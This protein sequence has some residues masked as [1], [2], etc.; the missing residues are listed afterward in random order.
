MLPFPAALVPLAAMPRWVLWRWQMKPERRSGKPRDPADRGSWTKP[1][2]TTEGRLARTDEDGD[3]RP[4][5]DLFPALSTGSFSGAGFAPRAEDGLLFLDL[6]ECRDKE[7]GAVAAWAAR[8]AA[9]CRSYCEVSPSGTGLRIVGLAGGYAGSPTKT[10]FVLTAEGAEAD[11]GAEGKGEIYRG[12]NYVTITFNA[13]PEA[14][15]ALADISA[16]AQDILLR[17]ALRRNA[18]VRGEISGPSRDPRAP[19][20]VVHETLSVIPNRQVSWHWWKETIGMAV[21]AATEGSEEGLAAWDEWSR[22]CEAY[23][24]GC[25]CDTE[26]ERMCVSPPDRTGFGTLW[27]EAAASETAAGRRWAGGPQWK[28][29]KTQLGGLSGLPGFEAAGSTDGAAE[30]NSE[31]ASPAGLAQGQERVRPTIQVVAGK[32]SETADA[33]EQALVLGGWPVYTRDRLLVM[34]SVKEV[35][36]RGGGKATVAGL[37]KMGPAAL[38]DVLAK[39]AVWVKWDGRSQRLVACDPPSAVV[40]V[41]LERPGPRPFPEVSGISATPGLRADG[42]IS[43]GTGY[44]P[45]L[46][47]HRVRDPHLHMPGG[48]NDRPPVRAD[49]EVALG[50]LNGLLEG[51][52]FVDD[53]DRAVALAMILTCVCRCA[54]PVAPVFAV[55][56]TMPGTGKSHLVDLASAIATGQRC[57]AAGAGR[58]DEETEKRL[59][60]LI[61][62]GYPLVSI[63][64]L[65]GT[66][67]SDTLSQ[68]VER[69][70]LRIRLLG[71]SDMLEVE[72]RTTFTVNGNGLTLSGDLVRRTM[73]CRMDAGVESPENRA[74]SFDPVKVVEGNRGPYVAAVLTVL[75]AHAEAGF[76]GAA[77]LKPVASYEDWSRFV[78]GALVWLGVKDP[79]ASMDR[80][81]VEDPDICA[82]RDMLTAWQRGLGTKKASAQEKDK[83]WTAREAIDAVMSGGMPDM[84]ARMMAAVSGGSS[85]EAAGIRGDLLEAMSK[86]AG[87]HG[88]IDSRRLGIWLGANAGRIVG[89]LRF[90]KH[91]TASG[92]LARW[93]V[94]RVRPDL[95]LVE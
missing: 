39:A 71:S 69:D 78:R 45:H 48:W 11:A 7:S 18:T 80:S 93:N 13:L 73:Q 72:C 65:N 84:T 67:R 76:P 59:G 61:A 68:A 90:V 50:L 22:G 1:P 17:N 81:R 31:K 62:A 47:V 55:T 52:P 92:F 36:V 12:A 35:K 30:G 57:P 95:R 44:D 64:N 16:V 32:L 42:S 89:G 91:A 4:Y 43:D 8:I 53:C 29:W 79:E 88:R 41:L 94:E 26:W 60:G 66:L 40:A 6:D 5:A 2:L 25:T 54:M 10:P 46:N 49:A 34:P 83:G 21:W 9:Q 33:A 24:T 70:R 86:V 27:F 38:S 20:D 63:D 87:D 37:Y 14:A 3:L 28:A 23:G 19:I 51:F 56:A 82:L 74:F 85:E 75:R 15:A 77:G 58:K